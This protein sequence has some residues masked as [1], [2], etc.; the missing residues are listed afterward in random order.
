M[1]AKEAFPDPQ[2]RR[3]DRTASSEI[4]LVE[5][6]NLPTEKTGVEGVIY[7]STA[8]A[9][10]APR[11]KWYPGRPAENAPCLSVTIEVSPRTFNHRLPQRVFDAACIPVKAWVA[12]NEATLLDFWHQGSTWLDDEVTGFKQGLAKLPPRS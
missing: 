3:P 11:V 7:I 6:A 2:H 12:L 4:A 10:H 1:R 9:S 5:M 8:Q